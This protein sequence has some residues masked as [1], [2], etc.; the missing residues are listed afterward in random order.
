MINLLPENYKKEL[1]AARANVVLLRYN[2]ITLSAIVFLMLACGIFYVM[3][4][5]NQRVAEEAS[6]ANVAK[7]SGYNDT[8][9][10]ADDYRSNLVTAKQILNNEVNYTSVV[11][12]ITSLLPNGVILDNVNLSAKDFGS[13]TIF[14][15]HAK[16]YDAV[17]QLKQNFQNSKLFSNVYFQNI[18]NGAD[19]SNKDYPISVSISVKI[20][21]V[22]P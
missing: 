13:Q 14:A 15:A 9:K 2:I 16:S 10:Q 11:F 12:G 7:A 1:G 6:Q 21:K 4:S 18:S 20:N 22:T 5:E 19:S 17:S 3:L 8:K